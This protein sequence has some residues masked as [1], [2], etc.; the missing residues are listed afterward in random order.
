MDFILPLLEDLGTSFIEIGAAFLEHPDQ[1]DVM[2]TDAKELTD[3]AAA[4]FM[5]GIDLIELIPL[6]KAIL[7]WFSKLQSINAERIVSLLCAIRFTT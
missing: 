3:R 5:E 7:K 2:E 6:Q 1:F 4:R